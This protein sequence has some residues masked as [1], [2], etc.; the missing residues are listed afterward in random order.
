[1]FENDENKNQK[2][3]NKFWK[4]Y[5]EKPIKLKNGIVQNPVLLVFNIITKN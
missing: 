2:N 5:K 3:D 4:C 1:M